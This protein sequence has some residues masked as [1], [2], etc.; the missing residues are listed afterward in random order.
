VNVPTQAMLP[1][2]H[3]SHSEMHVE[4]CHV[5]VLLLPW[6]GGTLQPQRRYFRVMSIFDSVLEN[7]NQQRAF[8]DMIRHDRA[9]YCT[10]VDHRTRFQRISPIQDIRRWCFTPTVGQSFIGRDACFKLTS[11]SASA[12]TSLHHDIYH[13][14]SIL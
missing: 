1:A 9:F 6:A 8:F 14:I 13:S 5:P 12:T 3:E 7:N 11:P 2:F 10:R 4:V